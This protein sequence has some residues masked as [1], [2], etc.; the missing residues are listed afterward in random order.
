MV[1]QAIGVRRRRR[2]FTPQFRFDAAHRVIDGKERVADVAGELDLNQSVLQTWVRDERWRMAEAGAGGRPDPRGGQPLLAN[3]R[4]ELNRLRAQVAEQ[5]ET[6]AFLKNASAYIAAQLHC[7]EF[8]AHY[9]S[10]EKCHD[11]EQ[12]R[13]EH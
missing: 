8:R 6:I 13:P 5:A 9:L 7:P 4:A 12:A 2:S 3:E 1:L 11:A 10:W